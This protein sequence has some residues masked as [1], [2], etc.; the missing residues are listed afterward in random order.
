MAAGRAVCLL[1]SLAAPA[2]GRVVASAEDVADGPWEEAVA[3]S[4]EVSRLSDEIHDVEL[5]ISDWRRN[6]ANTREYHEFQSDLLEQQIDIRK[7]Q[8]ATLQEQLKDHEASRRR[9]YTSKMCGMLVQ[10]FFFGG[11]QE[12][13]VHVARIC[14]GL[15]PLSLATPR[16]AGLRRSQTRGRQLAARPAPKDAA[17][18]EAQ[19]LGR[20]RHLLGV[21]LW[22][23]ARRADGLAAAEQRLE[24]QRAAEG[25]SLA[26]PVDDLKRRLDHLE[27]M[28]EA[29]RKEY[30]TESA[31]WK[32]EQAKLDDQENDLGDEVHELYAQKQEVAKQA[33]KGVVQQFCPVVRRNYA[34]NEDEIKAYVAEECG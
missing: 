11:D 18:G 4:N 9:Y 10:A 16:V 8:K 23:I 33:A 29:A 15:K 3:E 20:A 13:K 2:L 28:L 19:L 21:R 17:A 32:R 7:K 1:L 14:N 24:E 34:L 22:R 30:R 6:L 5:A 31:R 12:E 27:R 26:G 25:D